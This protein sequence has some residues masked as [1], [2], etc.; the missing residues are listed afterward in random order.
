[1]E[2]PKDLFQSSTR[3]S[4]GDEA[5]SSGLVFFSSLEE[6]QLQIK[7]RDLLHP[8]EIRM[9]LDFAAEI[10]RRS[11]LH[12]RIAGK[13][14]VNQLFPEVPSVSLQ[15]ST[16]SIG[17]P[18]FKNFTHPYAVSIAHDDKWIG[19]L[20]FPLSV[21]M[22]IDLESMSEKNR[23]IIPSILSDQE[24]EICKRAENPLEFLHILWTAKE[25]A[26]K[27]IGLGFRVPTEWYE[28]DL[29][30]N[31]STTPYKIHRCRFKQLSVYTSLSVTLPQGILTIA[32]PAQQNLEQ[33]MIRLLQ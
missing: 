20:C 32:F 13:M 14:A 2:E 15:I 26:G 9:G 23:T 4:V 28:I 16:G 8:D 21:P 17:E 24:K 29:V 11:F 22:G 31:I 33:A 27:A 5:F 3:F 25:A 18:Y 10:R 7:S 1:M 19:G 12:G 6:E 30:E